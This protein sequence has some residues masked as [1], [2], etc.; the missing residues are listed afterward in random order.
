MFLFLRY[1]I[2]GS[3][4]SRAYYIYTGALLQLFM[5]NFLPDHYLIF[6][7]PSKDPRK[8]IWLVLYQKEIDSSNLFLVNICDHHI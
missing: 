3:P 4:I 7:E 6:I 8:E 5:S 2:F 1:T